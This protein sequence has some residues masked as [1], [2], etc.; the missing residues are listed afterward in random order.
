M[1]MSSPMDATT[2]KSMILMAPLT[3]ITK[4]APMLVSAGSDNVV[5]ALL[6]KSVQL[7]RIRVNKGAANLNKE[8]LC[9]M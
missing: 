6:V 3:S 1:F 5:K 4:L 9:P 2:D 7:P 8:L